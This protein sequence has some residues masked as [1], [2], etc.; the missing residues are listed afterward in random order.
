MKVLWVHNFATNVMNSGQFMYISKDALDEI[1]A[2]IDLFYIGNL[3]NIFS[4]LMGFFRLL[5]IYPQYDIVHAQYG[6][7]CGLIVSILPGKRKFITIRGNDWAVYSNKKGFTF[8]HT[9]LARFFTKLSILLNNELIVVSERIKKEILEFLP[10][11]SIYVLPSP[12][13][14]NRWRA[15]KTKKNKVPN[16]LFVSNNLNDPNKRPE[17]FQQALMRVAKIR[18]VNVVFAS[19][20]GHNEMPK[21]FQDADLIVCTSETEGWPNCIKE[22]LASN[23]PF[24]STDVSDLYGIANRHPSCHIVEPDPFELS[25][26]ILESLESEVDN[27]LYKEVELFDISIFRNR[28]LEIYIN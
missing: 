11:K 9:R 4:V 8:F 15:N 25:K 28:L 16:I 17:L 26:A 12:I 22:G 2:S 18:E 23:T 5:S 3:R 21:L 19:G 10:K 13:E 14:L 1:D 20:I 24:V 7:L 27:T 6:S